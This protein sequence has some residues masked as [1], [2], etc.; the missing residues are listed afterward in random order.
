MSI[1]NT[2]IVRGVP[3]TFDQCIRSDESTSIDV[4]LAREQHARYMEALRIAGLEVVRV[5]PDERFPDCCFVEDPVVV[6]GG[7]GLMCSMGAASRRGEGD[8]L[9]GA[10]TGFGKST[11]EMEGAARLDGG[12]VMVAGQNI[13]VG[14][15]DRTNAGGIE[16]LR[17]MAEPGGYQVTAIEVHAALHLKSVCA[18][19]GGGH[20]AVVPGHVDEA[21]FQDYPLIE[22]AKS[23]EYSANCIDINGT[24]IVAD[25]FP[26]TQQ[27]IEAA[28]Y[29]TIVVAVSEFRK[30]DG[31]LSC[32]SIRF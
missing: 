16:A 8:T 31:G 28:G 7:N 17:S 19:L 32:L 1:L 6:V 18:Y 26:H 4:A 24:V 27:S 11:V 25:G 15:T 20:I 3:D 9:R 21:V 29:D 13:F 22:V 14:L 30:G 12:D 5:P 23:D 10:L 2:A